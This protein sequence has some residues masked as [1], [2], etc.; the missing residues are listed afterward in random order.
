[1]AMRAVEALLGETPVP[2]LSAAFTVLKFIVSSVQA[3][4]ESKEQLKVLA[5]AIAQFLGVLNAEFRGSRLIE[6]DC[7]QA[8]SDL[9]SLLDEIH[10]FIDKEQGRGFF[11]SLLTNDS[12]IASIEGFHRRIGL[13]AGTFQLA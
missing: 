3:V 12:R 1:M 4:R 5:L 10:R 9:E 6:T 13:V 8:L 11:K 2:G 7:K